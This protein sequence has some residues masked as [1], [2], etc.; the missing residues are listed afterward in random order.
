MRLT[1]VLLTICT[2]AFTSAPMPAAAGPIVESGNLLVNPGA[3]TGSLGPWE[4]I[5]F[6]VSD[7][8]ASL[9]AGTI[10]ATEGDWWFRTDSEIQFEPDDPG[11]I[12]R[13]QLIP[14]RQVAV[15]VRDLGEIT[16]VTFGGDAFG[17]YEILT[18]APTLVRMDGVFAIQFLD[19]DLDPLAGG[20]FGNGISQ[21][22]FFL[23]E[24]P[25]TALNFNETIEAPDGLA[26][27][28][29]LAEMNPRAVGSPG[30]LVRYRLGFDDLHLSVTYQVP[31][32]TGFALA[33]VGAFL[34]TFFS[35]V[36]RTRRATC[37]RATGWT[38]NGTTRLNWLTGCPTRG[39]RAMGLRVATLSST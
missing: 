17:V 35:F 24:N 22:P 2:A 39:P 21:I 13:A 10:D 8:P 30:D 9:P 5:G 25:E 20:N 31:E 34:V 16:A 23:D 29:F 6:S 27:L 11:G 33:A 38:A 36:S 28:L 32:P 1:T 26:F 12:T 15:D 4:S 37:L 3:E 19:K 7:Q 14:M 18:G